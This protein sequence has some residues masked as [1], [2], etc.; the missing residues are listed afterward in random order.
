MKLLSFALSL[1]ILAFCLLGIALTPA[2][3]APLSQT[4]VRDYGAKGDGVT[5]DTAAFQNAMNALSPDGGV[6]NVPT[7][8]YLIQSHLSIP[9]YVTL[10]GVWKIPTAFSQYH[11]STLLAV[12]GAGSEKGTPFITLHTN[13]V[14]KGITVYYPNQNPAKIIPYPWCVACGGGDNVSII[15]CLLVNPY[16][17]VDFGTNPSGRHFINGLYGQPLRRGIFVDQCYDIGRIQNVHFW[18]FWKWDEQSGIRNWMWKNSE[19][20]IFGRTDWEYVF[21]TF[22]FGY[23]IGYKFIQTKTGAMNGNLVGIGS[24]ASEFAVDVEQTQQPGLLIT[25]GEFVSLAGEKPTEVMI[26]PT[27]T[28]VVQFS[29][30]SFWG[31]AYQIAHIQGSGEVSFTGCN[32]VDW[33]KDGKGVPAIDL[34]GGDLIV[35]GCNFLKNAPQAL[36]GGYARSAVIMGNRMQGPVSVSN[37]AHANLQIGLNAA[38]KKPATPKPA[39]GVIQVDDSEAAPYVTF[40]GNWTFVSEGGNFGLGAHWTAKGNGAAKAIFHPRI[41]KTGK[42]SVSAY[43]GPD[44]NHDHAT[45]EPVTIHYAAGYHTQLVNLQNPKGKW[46]SLGTYLFKKGH[47][48]AIVMSNDANGNV[49]ADAIRL[50]P[51]R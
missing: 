33:D 49:L 39:A 47:T 18:T 27:H 17:G 29:N 31:P 43:F 42:Y 45:N 46:V 36:L 38:G 40:V 20:F 32:F 51:A 2:M 5:D 30:C 11:G 41:P 22:V 48:A 23:H 4:S 24:D 14:L 19:A 28:G 26:A 6:V 1:L 16:Q 50:A 35:N 7:G 25:N 44:P 21:N 9:E 10:E 37:P 13:S 34:E 12:E 8:N 15:D 3:A